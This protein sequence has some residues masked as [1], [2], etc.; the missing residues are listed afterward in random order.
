MYLYIHNVCYWTGNNR[1]WTLKEHIKTLKNTRVSDKYSGKILCIL[2]IMSDTSNKIQ[3]IDD[4]EKE[5]TDNLD[6]IVKYW[7]H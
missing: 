6:I 1:I 3:A 4:L 7:P 5:G 2:S